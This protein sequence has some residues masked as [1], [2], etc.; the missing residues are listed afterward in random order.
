MAVIG[1]EEE[2][3]LGAELQD[4]GQVICGLA[5]HIDAASPKQVVDLEGLRRRLPQ[6]PGHEVSD[7]V[8]NPRS[9]RLDKAETSGRKAVWNAPRHQR[10]ESGD[11]AEVRQSAA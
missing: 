5:R 8:G 3:L 4:V 6:L 1:P 7:Q 10:R 9:A 11:G 2:V